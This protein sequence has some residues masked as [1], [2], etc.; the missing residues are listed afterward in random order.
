MFFKAVTSFS[1]E[2]GGPL[3]PDLP[4]IEKHLRRIHCLRVATMI[5]ARAAAPASESEVKNT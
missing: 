2:R 1:E 5:L 3:L 4:T